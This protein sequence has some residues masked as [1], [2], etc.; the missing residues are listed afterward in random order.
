MRIL[1]VED[2]PTQLKLVTAV[3]T[4]VGHT[5]DGEMTAEA[6]TK[7][8]EKARPDL[9]MVDMRLPGMDGLTLV[10][11]IKSKST[12]RSIP[13]VAVTAYPEA[14]NRDE[15][16]AAGCQACI[17]KPIDTRG[18]PQQLESAAGKGS[19]A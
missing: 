11:L 5:V 16:L 6:A 10:R 17:I 8:I 18:L 1:I 2:D 9:I 4:G 15:L 19:K 12:T 7:A 14:Y 3:L 13:I